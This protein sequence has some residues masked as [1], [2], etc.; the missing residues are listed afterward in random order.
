M[1][2]GGD[3]ALGAGLP[4]VR[5]WIGMHAQRGEDDGTAGAWRINRPP[6]EALARFMRSEVGAAPEL[7]GTSSLIQ[8]AARDSAKGRRPG[9]GTVEQ[10]LEHQS[11]RHDALD[12]LLAS[13][14]TSTS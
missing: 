13:R 2:P 14:T 6:D 8:P 7:G 5:K 1:G 4:A 10:L 3:G 11:R 9:D 12:R